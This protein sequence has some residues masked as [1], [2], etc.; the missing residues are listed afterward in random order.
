MSTLVWK[1]KPVS[2]E[3]SERQLADYFKAL[4]HPVRIRLLRI[5]LEGKAANVGD[6]VEQFPLAQSTVSQHLRI[7]KAAGLVED[8]ADGVRRSYAVSPRSLGRLKRY[9][10]AL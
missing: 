5:L 4:G 1:T 7:L 8:T 10:G 3:E 2:E 9:V 6:L